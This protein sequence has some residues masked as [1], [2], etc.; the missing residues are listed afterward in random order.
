MLWLW[1]GICGAT[2]ALG[3]YVSKRWA[4]TGDAYLLVVMVLSYGLGSLAWAP[5]IKAKCNLA[6]MGMIWVLMASLVTVAL[7]VVVFH[8]RL[9]F[10]QWIGV[11][12]A[13]GAMF[14]IA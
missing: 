7:G 13:I 10:L 1:F 9:G 12:L 11:A 6:Q 2:F 8:E 5:I 4:M 14:L 3:E